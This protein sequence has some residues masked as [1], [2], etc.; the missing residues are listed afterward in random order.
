MDAAGHFTA[1]IEALD[2][3]M[4]GGGD[5]FSLFVDHDAA[6]RV[7][8][9]RA[10]FDAVERA[11]GDGQ[12]VVEGEDAAEVLVFAGLD[13]AVE[14]LDFFEEGVLLD[15]EVVGEGFERVELLDRA[16]FK[17]KLDEGR[18]DGLHDGVVA[19]GDRVVFIRADDLE[20]GVGLDLAAGVFVHEAAAGLAVDDEA[21]VHAGVVREVHGNAEALFTR[22]A[23]RQELEPAELNRSGAD[24][25]GLDQ[26]AGGGAGLVRGVGRRDDARVLDLAEE[27]VAGEAAGGE[28]HALRGADDGLLAGLV[29]KVVGHGLVVEAVARAADDAGDGAVFVHD[30]VVELAAGADDDVLELLELFVHRAD[31]AGAGAGL[32]FIGTRNGVAAFEE[33][34]VG[35]EFA[36]AVDNH[37]DR[38]VAAV[39]DGGE[40]VRVVDAEAVLQAVGDEELLAVL[41]ALGLLDRIDRAGDVAAA[42]GGVAADRGHLF[43][44]EDVETGATGLQGAG[45]A[46]EA[47]TD[48]DDVKR[49]VVL[50]NGLG[51][52]A[53][54]HGG[55]GHHGG[56][57]GDG[58]LEE[59]AAAGIDLGHS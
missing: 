43:N 48:D 4:R 58:G 56:G 26:H 50:G 49:F 46:G 41:D 27:D 1:G 10:A 16:H 40:E 18:V 19:D 35:H 13:E 2:R 30:E 45:H 57:S 47:R 44:H 51:G 5:D 29:F 12:T 37:L 21:E 15:A 7:V 31:V 55:G 28:H 3:L 6:H 22:V 36:A 54:V 34:L 38:V 24:A 32:D 25:E 14:L 23:V 33:H 52:D 8:D 11:L 59:A 53:G 42:D 9:L 20:E 17:R 39:G